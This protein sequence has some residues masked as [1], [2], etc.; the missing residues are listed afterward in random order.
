MSLPRQV[1]QQI[2]EIEEFEASIRAQT[3]EAEAPVE[4]VDVVEDEAVTVDAVPET[5]VSP[6]SVVDTTKVVEL[7]PAEDWQQKYL[8]LQ[9]KFNSEVPQLHAANREL[10]K[11]IAALKELL[12]QRAAAPQEHVI[13]DS[14]TEDEEEAYGKEHVDLNRRIVREAVTPLIAKISDLEQENI[15]LREVT[16]KTGSKVETMSFETRLYE[17]VP[18]FDAV[19]ADPR[20]VA[21]LD[22]TDPILRGPRRSVAQAAFSSGDADSIAAYVGLFRNSLPQAPVVPVVDSDLQSQVTPNRTS[23]ADTPFSKTGRVFTETEA[24][25]LFDKVTQL[26]KAGKYEEASKLEA[27]LTAAYSTGRVV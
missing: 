23:Q 27:E 15:K 4:P 18:D 19:N 5:V 21:W 17:K 13:T 24:S 7:K 25:K 3:A 16:V 6:E 10:T 11:E 1:Q 8:T 20:W 14:L 22:E 12:E 9:G 2:D 26:N